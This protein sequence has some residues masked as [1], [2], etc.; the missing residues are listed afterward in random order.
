MAC[1][2]NVSADAAAEPSIKALESKTFSVVVMADRRSKKAVIGFFL[3]VSEACKRTHRSYATGAP[4]TVWRTDAGLS[5]PMA[6]F[7]VGPAHS[8]ELIVRPH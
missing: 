4:E 1:N 5:G 7:L 8:V 2:T 6:A 3:C